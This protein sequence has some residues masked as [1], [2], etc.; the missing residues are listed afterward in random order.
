MEEPVSGGRTARGRFAAG[1]PGRPKGSRNRMTNRLTLS[2]LEDFQGHEEENLARL[3]RWF[4]P[5]YVRLM[6]RFVP[7]E[8]AAA[9][10]DFASYSAAETAAVAAAALEALKRVVCDE[11]SLDEVMAALERDPALG[12]DAAEEAAAG[13]LEP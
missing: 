13:A 1:N 6:S 11:G 2:L 8:V 9:R 4:F 5:E 3:R 12:A 10:P 7:R